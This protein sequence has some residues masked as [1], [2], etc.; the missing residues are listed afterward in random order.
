[1]LSSKPS[2]EKCPSTSVVALEKDKDSTSVATNW[3]AEVFFEPTVV[4]SSLPPAYS[5]AKAEFPFQVGVPET[6]SSLKKRI[7][8]CV[9]ICSGK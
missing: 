1:M 4:C 2:S 8:T 5:A 7:K 6:W 3:G 9:L